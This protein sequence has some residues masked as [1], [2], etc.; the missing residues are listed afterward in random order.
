MIGKIRHYA[1]ATANLF[2]SGPLQHIC[3]K[4]A[5]VCS[6]SLKIMQNVLNVAVKT[7]NYVCARG[8]NLQFQHLLVETNAQKLNYRIPLRS[9]LAGLRAKLKFLLKGREH[10]PNK[11]F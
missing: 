6:K 8:L 7:M 11:L 9:A 1:G 10:L 2:I 3:H 4:K 5:C